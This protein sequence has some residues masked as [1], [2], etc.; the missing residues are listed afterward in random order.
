MLAIFKG[1]YCRNLLASTTTFSRN[2]S[3]TFEP[4]FFWHEVSTGGILRRSGETNENR[5]MDELALVELAANRF[6]PCFDRIFVPKLADTLA[7]T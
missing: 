2:G 3:A 5:S 7:N 6:S 4:S 1:R